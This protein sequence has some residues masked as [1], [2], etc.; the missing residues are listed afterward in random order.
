MNFCWCTVAVKDLD[1]SIKFY[2]EIVGLPVERRFMAGPD[3]E[4]AFL[5]SGETKLELLEHKKEKK[6]FTGDGISLGFEVQSVDEK[7][8]FI[9]GKGLLIEGG[10]YQPNPHIKFF[11]VRDPNGLR[12]QFVENM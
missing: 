1:D 3:V 6:S 7:M 11:Y 10:P 12:V 8:K 4:I 2:Q 9:R 5:G